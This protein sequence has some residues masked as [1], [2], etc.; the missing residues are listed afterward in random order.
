MRKHPNSLERPAYLML[1][2]RHFHQLLGLFCVKSYMVNS[3]EEVL[4]YFW[5]FSCEDCW[6]L[7][8][9]PFADAIMEEQWSKRP[10]LPKETVTPDI[11][12]H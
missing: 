12:Q 6:M 2:L 10:D 3:E 5:K 8:N 4:D 1:I 7:M 9:A 11:H